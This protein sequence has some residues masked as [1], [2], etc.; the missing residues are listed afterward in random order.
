MEGRNGLGRKKEEPPPYTQSTS[1]REAARL[2]AARAGDANEIKGI[3]SIMS[4]NLLHATCETRVH[5]EFMATPIHAS[6]FISQG[7]RSARSIK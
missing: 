6:T 5:L 2:D 4:S 1:A 3:S 7:W